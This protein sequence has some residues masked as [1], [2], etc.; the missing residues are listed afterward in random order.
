M[1]LQMLPATEALATLLD[2]TDVISR[3]RSSLF[4]IGDGAGRYSTTTAFFNEVRDGD[5]RCH[6]GS[7]IANGKVFVGR[8]AGMV[9]RV[10]ALC[11]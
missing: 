7:R 11:W 2:F 3:S 8:R 5:W 6:F 4:R 1:P 10:G 9:M